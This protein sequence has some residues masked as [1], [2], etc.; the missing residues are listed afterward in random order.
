MAG[1]GFQANQYNP[2]QGF[3]PLPN[4]EYIA[5]ITEAEIKNTKAGNGQYVK[6]TWAI[7]DGQYANRKLWSN[8]NIVNPN[9]TAEKIGREEISAIAHAI[10]RPDASDT[11]LFMN[12]PCKIKVKIKQ[13]TGRDPQNEIKNWE[14]VGQ[15]SFPGQQA[16]FAQSHA[17][18]PAPAQAAPQPA[19]APAAAAPGMAPAPQAGAAVGYQGAPVAQQASA[20]KPPAPGQAPAAAP[21]WNQ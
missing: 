6:F 4:G 19:A 3:E 5:M 18:A 8:H 12:V 9:P 15:G 7:V 16:P 1:L 11:D 10:G 2:S 14:A 21:P 20:A 13:E 17:P